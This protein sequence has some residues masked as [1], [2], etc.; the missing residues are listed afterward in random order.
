[1]LY[2][3]RYCKNYVIVQF[4]FGTDLILSPLAAAAVWY[5]KLISLKLRKN[6]PH[7]LL[8]LIKHLIIVHMYNVPTSAYSI[9]EELSNV[10]IR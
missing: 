7:G 2:T 6:F 3:Y 1:M 9:L 10:S 5:K 8:L 4:I